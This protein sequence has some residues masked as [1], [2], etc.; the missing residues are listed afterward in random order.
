MTSDCCA[1]IGGFLLPGCGLIRLRTASE[2]TFPVNGE[3]FSWCDALKPF[4]ASGEGGSE[5]VRRR[6]RL[7]CINF[8]PITWSVRLY[9]GTSM[10][11]NVGNISIVP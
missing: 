4:P 6:M 11:Y 2:S 3:G 1:T 9:K 5:L 8:L 7:F 10:R